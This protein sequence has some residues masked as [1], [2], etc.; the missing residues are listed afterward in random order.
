LVFNSSGLI[1]MGQQSGHYPIDRRDGEIERLRVQGAAMAP[2]AA[3]MLDRIGVGPGWACLDLGCGPAGITPLLSER[4]GTSGR[5]V[6][7]DADPVFLEH[8]RGQVSG[9]VAFVRGDAYHTDLPSGTFDLVHTRFVASTAGEPEA[10]LREAIRL[11]RPGGTVALQEPDM[12]ALNCYPRHPAFDRL[13]AALEGAFTK[14]GA[15]IRLAQRLFAMVRHAGLEDVQYRPFLVGVRSTD[16]L[17]DYLPA[18]AE[19][20]RRTIVE[21]GLMTEGEL[22]TALAECRAHLRDPDTVFTTYVV[23]QVWGRTSRA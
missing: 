7:L 19:S 10:L 21:R 11:A 4:V 6:G 1:E 9:N 23:A 8:A 17:V 20:L 22:D 13:K 12:A 2:D 16:P 14:V 5:V 18:T 15:D 3:I